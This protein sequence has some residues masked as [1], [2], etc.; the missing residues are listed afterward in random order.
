[1]E[2]GKSSLAGGFFGVGAA[3]AAVKLGNLGSVNLAD[4]TSAP[5]AAD[6]AKARAE[7]AKAAQ[8][9]QLDQIREKG[10]YAWAQ[11]QKFEKLKEKVRAEVMAAHPGADP[12]SLEDEIARRI[13]EAMQEALRQESEHA[14][15]TGEPARPMLIDISV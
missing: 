13:K 1:M 15:R 6:K 10:L 5:T 8:Q 7:A 11:E 2:I 9:A 4:G 12:A 14:A 3:S